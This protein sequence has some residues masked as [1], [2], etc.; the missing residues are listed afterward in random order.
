MKR[1]LALMGS[2]R[3]NKNTDSILDYLLIGVNKSDYIINKL[4]VKDLDIHYC[5]GCDHC[6]RTSECVYNDDMQMV[7]ENI[8]N[9]DIVIFA[10]PIYFN[11]INSLSKNVVD[12]C[13]KY[14]SIKYILG[15]EYNR[16]ENRK[17]IFLSVGGAPYSH[18]Q[19]GG[20]IPVMDFFFKAIN[21]NYSGNYF[22]SNT[23]KLQVR[24]RIDIHQELYSIGNN[25][26][27]MENFYIHK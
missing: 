7:Y 27:H 26:E 10:A 23:D 4:I 22:I 2:P 15:Q 5:T 11:S 3:R 13:Q 9:S 18:N 19:F 24:D 12:R 8:D 21:V 16:N 25:I 1:I 6:G 20:A 14:W 17:G